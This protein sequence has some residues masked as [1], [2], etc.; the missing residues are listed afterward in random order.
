LALTL[1][2]CFS[3]SARAGGQVP[4]HPDAAL[5]DYDP[6]V[7]LDVVVD[8]RESQEGLERISL[9]YASPAGGRVPAY[10]YVPAAPGPHP[11]MLMMHGLP[12]DRTSMDPLAANYARMG[13][14]I[15][16]ISAPFARPDGSRAE[17]VT[18][19]SRDRDE[20][21]Q[22]IQDLRRGI[23][24]LV[25]RDDV[26]ADR[27]GYVG[28]SYGGAMGGLLAG[29]ED[30]I[31]AYVLFV[32]D[33]GLVDHFTGTDD[34]GAIPPERRDSWLAAMEPIE[35]IRF[36]GHAAPAALFFQQALQDTYVPRADGEAYAAAGSEP[37][38]VKW[39][40]QGHGIGAEMMR[41][42]VDWLGERIGLGNATTQALAGDGAPAR[43]L[44][45]YVGTFGNR[46]V[47]LDDGV[48][49]LQRI[50][51][52]T[53]QSGQRISAPK[54]EMVPSGGDRFTL[55]LVPTA[56]IEFVRSEGRVVTIRVRLPDG[57]WQESRRTS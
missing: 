19:T 40:D 18:F 56:A 38:T 53:A 1:A 36:V 28:G 23:D 31:D 41:D 21:I 14:V 5:F 50:D 4:R 6:G 7:P 20:Q 48:L 30:R 29:V 3:G 37:K 9:S 10:L 8:G 24:L 52:P 17:P 12:G 57:T 45:D 2:A 13:A 46:Q 25:E 27:L 33:G 49:F 22:L 11:G 16:S 42:Q 44:D 51:T 15:L 32:G 54:L 39:Y 55:R 34:A 43:G 47:T 26:D 35:P